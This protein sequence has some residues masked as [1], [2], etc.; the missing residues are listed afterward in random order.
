M[1]TQEST[2]MIVYRICEVISA[3]NINILPPS[4]L[5]EEKN[6]Y[7]SAL[8]STLRWI[9]PTRWE[10]NVYVM[11]TFSVFLF[12]CDLFYC[13]TCL[14]SNYN[15]LLLRKKRECL[16]SYMQMHSRPKQILSEE[17]HVLKLKR[18]FEWCVLH[19]NVKFLQ[20]WPDYI[21][22]HKWLRRD[23][24]VFICVLLVMKLWKTEMTACRPQSEDRKRVT[25]Q[26]AP[27]EG[28]YL[29]VSHRGNPLQ[30]ALVPAS[31][32]A[33]RCC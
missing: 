8:N 5:R 7:N 33:C 18:L 3:A 20:K 21:F 22:R 9:H 1:K 19:R 13:P 29:S 2:E 25:G 32:K 23:Q 11:F 28:F 30:A 14:E 17:S 4:F 6:S 16:Q 27:R 15:I 10:L 26:K 12:W 24:G 31:V